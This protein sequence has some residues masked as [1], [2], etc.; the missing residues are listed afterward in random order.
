MAAETNHWVEFLGV[1]FGPPTSA[2]FWQHLSLSNV[3]DPAGSSNLSLRYMEILKTRSACP[4][5]PGS[6]ADPYLLNTLIFGPSFQN[7]VLKT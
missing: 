7:H 2:A 3:F 4:R 6:Q 5:A 1:F